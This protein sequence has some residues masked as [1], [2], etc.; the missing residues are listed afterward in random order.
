MRRLLAMPIEGWVLLYLLL[1]LPNVMITRLVVTT[2][3]PALGRP[4]T[5]LET[6]P[7]SLIISLVT[8]YLFIWL[9]G[10]HRDAKGFQLGRLRLPRP[11]RWTVLGVSILIGSAIYISVRE[12]KARTAPPLTSAA[13]GPSEEGVRAEC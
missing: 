11:D 4:L 6:L 3:H 7:A 2:P 1:Y 5:G 9:S 10:W 8:T 12:R 13:Q